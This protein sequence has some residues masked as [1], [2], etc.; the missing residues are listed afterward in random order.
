MWLNEEYVNLYQGGMEN[1]YSSLDFA[2]S[3]KFFGL[4]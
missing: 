4:I 2:G 3:E 1:S